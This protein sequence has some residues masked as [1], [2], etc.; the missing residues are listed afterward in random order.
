MRVSGEATQLVEARHSPAAFPGGVDQPARGTRGQRGKGNVERRVQVER[1]A[2]LAGQLVDDEPGTF[3]EPAWQGVVAGQRRKVAQHRRPADRDD[4]GREAV[5]GRRAAL[6]GRCDLDQAARVAGV[7]ARNGATA[8]DDSSAA[9][10][11]DLGEHLAEG[12]SVAPLVDEGGSRGA[13]ALQ[14]PRLTLGEL[15]PDGGKLLRQWRLAGRGRTMEDDHGRTGHGRPSLAT[16]GQVPKRVR[17]YIGLGANVGEPRVALANAVRALAAMPGVH[18]RGMS[19]LYETR[20][21]GL[22]DQ[23]DF[24]NAVAALDVPAGPDPETGAL[25][26]LAALKAL[27]QAIGRVARQRWGPRE[28][29]LDLLVFGRHQIDVRRPDDGWLKV[30]HPEAQQRLFVL[31]PLADLAPGLVPPGWG[32]S[33]ATARQRRETEEGPGAVRRVGPLAEAS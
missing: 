28:V 22:T 30:P 26:L 1:Q 33:V 29:D 6:A 5:V 16:G 8:E 7:E 3:L 27:E 12:E 14:R 18:L 31:A 23:P 15:E 11:R 25:A 4:V 9:R 10:R 19:S 2:L 13:G 24:L 17:A 20:P 32:E 21:V